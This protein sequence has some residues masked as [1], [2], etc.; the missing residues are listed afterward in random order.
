M[1]NRHEDNCPFTFERTLYESK[2]TDNLLE[3]VTSGR[4]SV[5]EGIERL[6]KLPFEDIGIAGTRVPGPQQ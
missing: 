5:A 1:F 3:T 2:T 6:K 4:S